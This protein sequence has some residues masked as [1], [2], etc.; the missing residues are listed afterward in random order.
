MSVDLNEL[1]GRLSADVRERI[2]REN[3]HSHDARWFLKVAVECGFDLA[4]RLNQSTLR[5]MART[6]MRR[7][8][9][10]SGCGP[11][12]TTEDLA[13]VL[14]LAMEVYFP[15][16]MLEGEAE[17]VDETSAR[18][19]VTRCLVQEEVTRAGVQDL[20]ECACPYRHLGWLEACGYSGKVEIRKSML[21]GDLVCEF[22]IT[23]LSR[24]PD[25]EP[26]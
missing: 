5:S 14:G 13:K 21:R 2:I 15:P 17:A 16:P 20:Y 1:K 12:E 7:L 19:T 26:R 22:S 25:D 4:N 11:I 3:W 8:I 6:E 24:L 23:E 18:G 9:D 10:A